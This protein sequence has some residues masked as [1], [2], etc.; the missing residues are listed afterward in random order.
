MSKQSVTVIGLGPMGQA[1]V[2]ALLE[3][4]HEVTVWNRTAS[5]AGEVVSKGAKL[6]PTVAEALKAN[7]LVILSLTDYAAMY[8]ILGE[9]TDALAGKTVVNLSSDTPE[10]TRA[11]AKW[12]ESHGGRHVTGGVNSSPTGIGAPESFTF[13][14]GPK[15]AF[16]ASQETLQ[17]LTKTDYKGEDPGLAALYYQLQ[18]NVFWTTVTSWLH[19]LAVADANGIKAQD[20][21]PYISPQLAQMPAFLGYYSPRIDEGNYAGDIE[22]LSMAV[23]SIDHVVETARDSGVDTSL[24]AKVQEIFRRGIEAGRSEDSATSLVEIFKKPA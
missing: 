7:D 5:K 1:M 16:E 4:G 23:A 3:N 15:D 24:P 8:A 20:F 21:L 11:G 2:S 14:S 13:Y 9:A 19:T 6:A 17:V 10:K 12:I 18:L 22:R